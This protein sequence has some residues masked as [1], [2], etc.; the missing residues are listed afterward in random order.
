[1]HDEVLSRIAEYTKRADDR[2]SSALGVLV[3]SV[4][5]VAMHTEAQTTRA[6]TQF[7]GVARI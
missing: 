2:T 6:A 3:G 1:M 4:E 5:E 7:K